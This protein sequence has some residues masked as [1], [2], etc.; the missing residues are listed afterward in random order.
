MN[1]ASELLD[2]Q[3]IMTADIELLESIKDIGPIVAKHIVAF[4][5]NEE[6][7]DIVEELI[8]LGVNWPKI[9]KALAENL[10]LLGETWVLTG[11][12]SQLKR[13]DVKQQLQSFGAKVSGSVSKNTTRVVAGE[14]AGSKLTKA[15][16]L[17]IEVMDEQGF[18]DYLAKLPL[19]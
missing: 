2:I 4:F 15:T 18:I 19:P 11:T 14:S 7:R 16:D 12:L 8:S 3:S 5:A 9:T 1:L 13:N 6:N 17:G 10:P